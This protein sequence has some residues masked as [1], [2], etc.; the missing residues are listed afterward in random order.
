MESPYRLS[1][2]IEEALEVGLHLP[3]TRIA[4]LSILA[5]SSFQYLDQRLRYVR[6]E[7]S[8]VLGLPADDGLHEQSFILC[9]EGLSARDQLVKHDSKRVDVSP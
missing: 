5:E 7:C 3:A 4:S 8:H 9:H 1:A 6:A 2:L